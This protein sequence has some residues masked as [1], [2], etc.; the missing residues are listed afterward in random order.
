MGYEVEIKYHVKNRSELEARLAG[1]GVVPEA[2]V[3]Q[4]DVYLVHPCRDFAATGEAFRLRREDESLCFTYKGR[5]L[6]GPT[7]TREEIEVP[8]GGQ[9]PGSR[10]DLVRLLD[11]LGFRA[12][13]AVRKTRT[14][15]R[16]CR[17][18]LALN[19][20]LDE[21]EGLGVFAEVETLANGPDDLPQSRAQVA[22]MAHD[23]GLTHVEPRSYLRMMLDRQQA[24][25]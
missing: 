20:A 12:L 5:R 23:L 14:V 11:R 9:E 10:E 2:T 3:Q 25:A 7:K 15:Y 1:L 19:V 18:G 21:A 22:A 4:E 6:E 8:V 16:L 13:L 17:E 24:E